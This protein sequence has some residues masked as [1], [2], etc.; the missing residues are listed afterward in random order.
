MDSMDSIHRNSPKKVRYV[1]SK[2]MG[3][4]TPCRGHIRV[5]RSAVFYLRFR[6]MTICFFCMMMHSWPNKKKLKVYE[7]AW[8]R[9]D[10]ILLSTKALGGLGL[11]NH[12]KMTWNIG[13]VNW[14]MAFTQVGNGSLEIQLSWSLICKRGTRT[15]VDN[16]S[17]CISMIRL[18]SLSRIAR[19][20]VVSFC[21]PAVVWWHF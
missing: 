2:A 7:T 3:I 15:C 11:R 19:G 21:V 9:S 8:Y 1:T 16:I 13:C 18:V 14:E 20:E 4:K 17:K 10:R 5:R 12:Y 6:N